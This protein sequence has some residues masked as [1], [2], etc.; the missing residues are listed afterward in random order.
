MGQNPQED[1]I[2]SIIVQLGAEKTGT[3][4]F[5]Q[6]LKAIQLQREL[7]KRFSD[8]E[9][10]FLQAFVAMGGGIDR[11]GVVSS[12]RLR[13]VIKDDFN[14]TFKIELLEDLDTEQDGFLNF[15]EFK[16]LFS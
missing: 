5:T 15:Q 13:K 16:Q 4:D 3:L 7:E 14:L 2:K 6:F 8:N 10:D 9:A 11:S 12:E 1:D